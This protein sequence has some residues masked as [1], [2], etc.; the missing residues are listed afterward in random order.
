MAKAH[1]NYENKTLGERQ[2]FFSRIL[3]LLLMHLHA[4]GYDVR[5]GHC[6]R[7][8]NCYT[9]N[10]NSVHKEKLAIDLN[11][12]KAPAVGERPVLLIGKEAQEAHEILH[13]YWD[14]L[15]GAPRIENDLN[16]YSVE[17]Q[18]RW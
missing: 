16:H 10:K 11:L 17:Y 4:R 15:G 6:M 5:L 1:G 3:V 12:T 8:R 14:T 2:E 13:D 7:C 18:G 9:G